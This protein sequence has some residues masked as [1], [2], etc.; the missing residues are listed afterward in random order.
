MEELISSSEECKITNE[1]AKVIDLETFQ[2]KKFRE[3]DAGDG[4]VREDHLLYGF[5]LIVCVI[6]LI[7]C[8]FLVALDQ[9][10]TAAVLTTI[11]DHFQEF[12]KMTWIT[13]A[14][15]MPMGV[16]SQVW[17][18]L[19]ISFG[20][21]WIVIAGIILFEIGSLVAAISSSMNMFIGGRAIQGVGGSSIMTVVMVI[22]T[23]ITTIDK[24]PLVLASL[25][26]TFVVASVLGPIIGGIFGT[27]VSWRWCFYLN[28][29]FG[30]VIFP[31]FIFTYKPKPPVGT[32]FEKLNTVDFLNCG[33]MMSSLVLLLLA[34]SFGETGNTW[35]SSSV[36]CCF[37]LGSLLLVAFCIDNFKYSKYPAIPPDIVSNVKADMA[38]L[39]FIMNFSCFMVL[40][41]FLSIYFENV[42]GHNAFHTGL[43]LIPCAIPVALSAMF[44]AVIMKK[45][46]LIKPICL[47]SAVMLPISVGLL[48]LL[49]VQENMGRSIGF[50][51]LLG[52]ATGLNFQGP[53]MSGLILAPK[54]PGSNILTMALFNSGRNI[55]SAF[56]SLIAGVI[57]SATLK[58][59]LP[60]VASKLQETGISLTDVV[61]QISL[62]QEMN[63]HDQNLVINQIMHSIQNVFYLGLALSFVAFICTLFISDKKLPESDEVE[64]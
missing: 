51:I 58:S 41:Q 36:I 50:Q 46:L 20:R 47:I 27:Y 63:A 6:S 22:A 54:T 40:I 10:I 61:S 34:L 4:T 53:M 52:I 15:L 1:S 2:V 19:S 43:S 29:C 25:S 23:E 37:V 33:L 21:K 24:K 44:S 3:S 7:L 14:F 38:F 28:I 64:A 42:A 30:A 57:Y 5:K 55:A 12:N 31:F 35:K 39:A 60:Q 59:A 32:F 16:C 8:V 62:L 56:F 11:S 17:A 18:R 26:S 45:Y 9:M 13:A 49:P 48:L